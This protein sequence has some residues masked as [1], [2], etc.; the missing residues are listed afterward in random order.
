MGDREEGAALTETIAA[1]GI[2]CAVLLILSSAF[3]SISRSGASVKDR[4]LFTFAMLRADELLR[5]RM[6]AV[7]VP[8]WERHVPIVEGGSYIELPWYQGNRNHHIKLF[9]ADNELLLEADENGKQ[10]RIVLF[11][12][13]EGAAIDIMRDQDDVPLALLIRITAR[14]WEYL[15]R[16]A[17]SSQPVTRGLP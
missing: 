8:Y 6:G 4:V 12:N 15:S 9:F 14:N 13:I 3:A 7:T 10:E 17:F 5:N 1:F 2:I 16:I 11:K